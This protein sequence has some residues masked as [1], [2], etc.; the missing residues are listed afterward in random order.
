MNPRTKK[1]TGKS[2]WF[3]AAL[4]VL[5]DEGVSGVR[6]ERLARDL[7]VTK[8]GF[9]WHFVDRQD[10]LMQL[11]DYW[12]HEYTAVVTE[13]VELRMLDPKTRLLRIAEIV[14]DHD[15]GGFDLSFW[16]WTAHD[17]EV[18]RRVARVI[19][20]RLEFVGEAFAEL[21]FEGDELEM[22]TRLFVCYEPW[23]RTTYPRVSKKRLREL[24]HLRLALLTDR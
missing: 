14:L 22:R 1:R 4:Q 12:A 2:D 13:N 8:G 5:A 7:G 10:L 19:R 16:A 18:A 17:P 20:T 21:G 23:E 15:L 6:I 24:M 3:Q 9:Y 11:L